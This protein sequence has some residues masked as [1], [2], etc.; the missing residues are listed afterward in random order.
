MTK[1]Y[2]YSKMCDAG[3]YLGIRPRETG[4]VHIFSADFGPF[5]ALSL[6]VYAV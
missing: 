2:E 3:R 5:L 1:S 6:Y 4:Q